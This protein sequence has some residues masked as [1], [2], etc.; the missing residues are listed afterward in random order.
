MEKS[1]KIAIVLL[2]AAL[3]VWWFMKR[4]EYFEQCNGKDKSMDYQYQEKTDR[5]CQGN[6]ECNNS[7]VCNKGKCV[8]A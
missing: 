4:N 8:T 3:L 5:T 7:R 2:I 6:C 1:L